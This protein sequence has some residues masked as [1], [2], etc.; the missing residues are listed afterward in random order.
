MLKAVALALLLVF[1]GDIVSPALFGNA[2]STLPACCLRDGKHR[3]MQRMSGVE[4][5]GLP[6]WKAAQQQCPNFPKNSTAMR[7]ACSAAP[8]S[9]SA[10]TPVF[11]HPASKVQTDARYRVSLIRGWQKRGPPSLT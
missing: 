9:R 3:C 7:G 10:I 8:P 6:R 4:E 11:T 1:T 5:G 2:A